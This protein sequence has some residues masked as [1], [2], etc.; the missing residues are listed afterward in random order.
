MSQSL[1]ERDDDRIA[2][3]VSSYD[4]VVITGTMPSICYVEGM[5]RFL[6]ANGCDSAWKKDPV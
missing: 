2:G 3:V 6:Y 5:S 4:R 1:T